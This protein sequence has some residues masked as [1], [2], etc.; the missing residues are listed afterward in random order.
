VDTLEVAVVEVWMEIV[1]E[2]EVILLDDVPTVAE[3]TTVVGFEELS[4]VSVVVGIVNVGIV[5]FV[6][7]N[8]VGTVIL[9][10]MVDRVSETVVVAE[11]RVVKDE[12]LD[13]LLVP[14]VGTILVVVVGVVRIDEV[15]EVDLGGVNVV[16]LARVVVLMFVK[17]VVGKI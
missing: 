17:P 12:M 6:V 8:P 10:V 14:N 11:R 1:T 5:K 15:D 4:D 2:D 16:K 7:G 13:T 9:K 3:V